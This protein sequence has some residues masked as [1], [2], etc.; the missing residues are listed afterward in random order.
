[1]K[2]RI[3]NYFKESGI[4]HSEVANLANKYYLTYGLAIRGLVERHPEIDI[5][6]YD[7]KVDGALPLETILK[8]DPALRDMIQSMTI[9]KKWLFTNAG[10]SHA[11]RVIRILGLQGLF[12][13]MTFCNY[14]EPRFVCKPDRK[15]FEKAMED[16][17]VQDPSL[18]YFVDDSLANIDAAKQSYDPQQGPAFGQLTRE[19]ISKVVT[20]D[21]EG[22]VIW[23]IGQLPK[24]WY[25]TKKR[26]LRAQRKMEAAARE[27]AVIAAKKAALEAA[28]TPT[29][30]PAKPKSW[31]ELLRSKNPA[32]ATA[33]V[34]PSD[35]AS[36]KAVVG[37][38][39]VVN[40]NGTQF[41][42]IADVLHKY[43]PSYS[44]PLIQPRGLVNNGNMCFM[45][46]I[47]QPLLHCPPFYNLLMQIGKHVVHSFKSS[48]PLV[49]S[50][51]MYLNEFIPTT[52]N[53]P[54][55]GPPFVPEYV[56]DAVRGLKRFDSMRGRQEDCQEFMGFLLDGLHEEFFA[57]MKDKP[58][59]SDL[60]NSLD[61]D[62]SESGVSEDEWMEVT[63]P[64]NKASYTRSTQFSATPITTIFSGQLRS[65]LRIP[66]Q[67]DS[68]TLEP[69]QSLQLD[70]TP[71]NVHTIEDALLNSTIPE[72]LDGF[73]SSE[74]GGVTVEATKKIFIE[75]VPPVLVLH[76]KRFIYTK[77]GG[78]QKLHK[79]VGYKTVLNLQ[80]EIISPARRPSSPIPYK[81]FGV[82]YHHG[83]TAA[84]GHYTCDVLRQNA[85]WLHIDDTNIAVISENDVTVD[86]QGIPAPYSSPKPSHSTLINGNS[87]ESAALAAAL[88]AS[89][90]AASKSSDGVAYVLFYIRSDQKTSAPSSGATTP[91][92]TTASGTPVSKPTTNGHH[93]K[94][95]QAPWSTPKK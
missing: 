76:L 88:A 39:R 94:T 72:V 16:A 53:L 84:G 18:C 56:Y 38:G 70:L 6:D 20:K 47:L 35:T 86:A 89:S 25:P 63:G 78:T 4:P 30:T 82:V 7:D 87:S 32:S 45:N 59:G 75:Q 31:A 71:D 15:A 58:A 34:L 24:G 46:A 91:T 14:Q 93:A 33:V 66:S 68:V 8:E 54:D 79:Q 50:L 92:R 60:D 29:A 5:K 74:K 85:E 37:A 17:G 23:S 19:D 81:L 48:T 28:P 42:G 27:A 22:P 9:G 64:K 49:D 1:M 67:K 80:P 43:K 62:S 69:F 77:D 21:D 52:K 55:Y 40:G 11:R 2:D 57:A 13:G 36:D 44:S 73:T 95:T 65:I 83:R 10:E 41:D 51:I 26:L 90:I 3:E 61:Q 12:H